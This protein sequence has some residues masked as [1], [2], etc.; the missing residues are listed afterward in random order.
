MLKEPTIQKFSSPTPKSIYNFEPGNIITRV[1]AAIKKRIRHNKNLGIEQTVISGR[2]DSWRGERLEFIGVQNNMIYLLDSDG[3]ELKLELEDWAQGWALYI[4]PHINH[5]PKNKDD[6]NKNKLQKF[7]DCMNNFKIKKN[8]TTT[9]PFEFAELFHTGVF[10]YNLDKKKLCEIAIHAYRGIYAGIPEPKPFDDMIWKISCKLGF[11]PTVSNFLKYAAENGWDFPENW[12]LHEVFATGI[13]S[14]EITNH[15]ALRIALNGWEQ[16]MNGDYIPET[17]FAGMKA[18]GERLDLHPTIKNLASY[19]I[20]QSWADAEDVDKT[21]FDPT[22]LAPYADVFTTGVLS[23]SLDKYTL[24]KDAMNAWHQCGVGDGIP[25]NIGVGMNLIGQQLGFSPTIKNLLFYAV[26]NG[27]RVAREDDAKHSPA[28]FSDIFIN[29]FIEG[30]MDYMA[31]CQITANALLLCR[32]N[33]EK[34][35]NFELGMAAVEQRLGFKPTI[36]KIMAIAI[37]NGWC[38]LTPEN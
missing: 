32:Y 34:P 2:D 9:P 7:A 5:T 20:C 16:C 24:L 31:L 6:Q 35:K 26:E 27:W 14:D 37:A 25:A 18:I 3:A 17:F 22:G 15:N 30:E 38:E 36:E 8:N 10:D 33:A 28:P 4:P 29:G 21:V 23:D 13:L 19:A 12:I 11:S 1:E